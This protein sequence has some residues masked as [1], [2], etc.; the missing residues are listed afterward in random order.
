MTS[1][2]LTTK[3]N[4]INSIFLIKMKLQIFKFMKG[5]KWNEFFV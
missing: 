3:Y 2:Y 4:D 1:P 5:V